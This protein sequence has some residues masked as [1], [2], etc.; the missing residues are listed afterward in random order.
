MAPDTRRDPDEGIDK[1]RPIEDD[2]IKRV[3]ELVQIISSPVPPM[4]KL[5]QVDP[6]DA[7]PGGGYEA[8]QEKR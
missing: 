2:P 8:I 7:S 6:L 5:K 3:R 4:A 1:T